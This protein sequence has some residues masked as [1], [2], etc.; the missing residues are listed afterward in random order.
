[1]FLD[2]PEYISTFWLFVIEIKVIEKCS[3]V[4]S[5]N[6]K[7][8]LEFTVEFVSSLG[9]LSL[10]RDSLTQMHYSSKINMTTASDYNNTLL[11]VEL[12]ALVLL[13]ST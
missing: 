5:T 7:T 11:R 10:V 4:A 12:K 2:R 13:I 6:N 3:F 9:I 8:T 1:M